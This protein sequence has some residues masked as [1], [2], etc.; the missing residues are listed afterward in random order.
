MRIICLH[1]SADLYG[2]DRSFLQ[3]ISYLV[4]TKKYDLITV[5][6]PRKGPLVNELE[7]FNVSIIYWDMSLLSKT[8]LK[9]LQWHKIVFPLLQFTK[10]RREL[11]KYDVVYC[12]TSVILDYFFIAPFITNKKIIHVREIP[13]NWLSKLLSRL[14]NRANGSVIFNS[15]ATSEAFNVKCPSFTIYNAF[16][17]F[18]PNSIVTKQDNAA[19]F[20]L[21]ILII[22]RIN[23][24]KG[25]DLLLTALKELYNRES[26]FLKI[27]GDSAQGNE[28]YTNSLKSQIK[29]FGLEERVSID[30]FLST[31]QSAYE[32]TD[33]V[34]IP[35]KKPEP[36]GRIA[37][38]A[39]S[40]KKP[41]IAAN[42]GGLTEIVVNKKSG[43][44][45]KPNNA[46]DLRLK[47]SEYINNPELLQIHGEAS[48][49]IFKEKFSTNKLHV[50]LDKVFNQ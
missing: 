48:Y 6:L 24:W 31:P 50:E 41:V 11:L 12:N 13:N 33:I 9:K 29:E 49:A 10:K 45:F 27:V 34:I 46:I 7:K 16:E 40:L 3:V 43:F 20:V 5:V 18:K 17:G 23:G 30:G 25:Q 4:E 38:E 37:I 15:I 36:F 28:F 21:K 35:S 47:I 8:Y 44:L 26:F 19:N 32:W 39:M 22:G 1:Q 14:I 2:S 42:H